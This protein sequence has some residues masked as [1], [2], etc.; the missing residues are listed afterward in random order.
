MHCPVLT[1]RLCV[2]VLAIHCPVLTWRM[3]PLVFVD[4]VQYGH[5]TSRSTWGVRYRAL[6]SLCHTLHSLI[7]SLLSII[8]P[9]PARPHVQVSAYALAMR[10]PV[11]TRVCSTRLLRVP[12]TDYPMAY[13]LAT[14]Y[15][16]P[17]PLY[18]PTSS[19]RLLWTW[20]L[21]KTPP[22][23]LPP[24]A[25]AMPCPVLT[26]NMLCPVLRHRYAI[27]GT[28]HQHAMSS[29]NHRYANSGTNL[30]TS[31]DQ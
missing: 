23:T 15:P 14:R 3:Q 26:I 8:Y 18:P 16:V 6:N 30:S 28:N 12:G 22:S 1:Y 21:R 27:S 25:I 13:G 10:C 31:R 4:A 11:L 29:R 17:D 19:S 5:D 9:L 24:Y 20:A 7:L 2:Y